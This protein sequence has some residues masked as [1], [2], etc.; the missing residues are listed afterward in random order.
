MP[1]SVFDNKKKFSKGEK[2]EPEETKGE[3]IRKKLKDAMERTS[4]KRLPK[5]NPKN[6]TEIDKSL[7]NLKSDFRFPKKETG[8]RTGRPK[9]MRPQPEAPRKPEQDKEMQPLAK[10]GRAG[11]KSGSKG[12]KLAMKGKGRAYGKNS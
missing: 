3:I 1:T 5:R 4:E 11:Y 8:P 10:G 2:F 6:I 12:C 9:T 7:K